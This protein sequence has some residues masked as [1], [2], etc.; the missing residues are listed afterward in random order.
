METPQQLQQLTQDPDLT[1]Y[2]RDASLLTTPLTLLWVDRHGPDALTWDPDTI[3]R[4]VRNEC[5]DPVPDLVV[6]RLLAGTTL[7]LTDRFYSN[8]S[9]FIDLTNVMAGS[10][11]DPDLFDPAEIDEAAWAVTEALLFEPP[12][13]PDH[14]FADEIVRYLEQRLRYEGFVTVPIALRLPGLRTDHL[15]G[16]AADDPE[17]LRQ[18]D[19]RR[20]EVDRVV[21][22]HLRILFRQLQNLPLRHGSTEGL[23]EKI[24]QLGGAAS[25]P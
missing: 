20:R 5:R 22:D 13:D 17:I 15:Q 11:I 7:A 9:D 18:A 23:L 2:W 16:V 10:L 1:D 6:D 12:E 4:T 19:D 21:R 3:A 25:P 8:L 24:R 14:P